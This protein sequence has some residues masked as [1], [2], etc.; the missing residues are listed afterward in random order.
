M[1]KLHISFMTNLRN[2]EFFALFSLLESVLKENRT[3]NTS[4]IQVTE[5][6]ESHRKE[7]LLIKDTKRRHHLTKVISNQ[8]HSRTEYLTCLRMKIDAELLSHIPE[9]R[10]A[11]DRLKLWLRS[12]SKDVYTSSI[13]SQGQ[14][15]KFMM[16]DKDNNIDIQE[17]TTLLN[18]DD[19]LEAIADIT[20]SI[21]SNY[22]DRL[23]DKNY[24]SV[25]G[26][27]IRGAAYADLQMLIQLMEV[28]YRLSMNEEEKEHLAM[29]SQDL[30]GIITAFHTKLKIRNTKTKNKKE[31]AA[32]VK[33]FINSQLIPQKALPLGTTQELKSD[34]S[35]GSVTDTAK[36]NPRDEGKDTKPNTGDSTI[37]KETEKDDDDG[38]LPPIN[39]N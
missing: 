18:L 33:E 19:L 21:N 14:L 30:N 4:L 38:K 16:H 8:V 7:L 23:K 35:T 34:P 12:Y 13:E 3:E 27:E 39:R 36:L 6:I 22:M 15:V 25:K 10:I 5:R 9:N 1:E 32:A 28:S 29:L 31:V 11:A 2:K 37:K 26:K 24:K 17:A 20:E